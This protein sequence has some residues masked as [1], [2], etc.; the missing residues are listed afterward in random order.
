MRSEVRSLNRRSFLQMSSAIASAFGL[1]PATVTQLAKG[2]ES[3]PIA[4]A[5]FA[6]FLHFGRIF[7]QALKD[8]GS[9]PLGR[10][11]S[12][13]D[14]MSFSLDELMRS[15][16][17]LVKRLGGEDSPLALILKQAES[18]FRKQVAAVLAKPLD[19][20]WQ[21]LPKGCRSL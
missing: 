8:T 2:P 6:T 20:K 21:D 3:N 15:K 5:D 1:A 18:G 9:G 16:P 12:D 11:A 17:D 19:T 10:Q 13:T 7:T 4:D 14:L